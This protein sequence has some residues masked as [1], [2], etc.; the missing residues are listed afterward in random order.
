MLRSVVY[1]QRATGR[2]ERPN[3]AVGPHTRASCGGHD[4]VVS[5][6]Q[7]RRQ[8]CNMSAWFPLIGN[9][10]AVL[11]LVRYSLIVYRKPDMLRSLQGGSEPAAVP[12]H[13]KSDGS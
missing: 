10:G 1:A 11:S 4:A 3:T 13:Q 8:Q 7:Y 5:D 6:R 9:A 2:S 12:V